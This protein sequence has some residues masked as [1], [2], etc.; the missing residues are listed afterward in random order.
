MVEFSLVVLHQMLM[1]LNKLS[2]PVV[3][4]EAEAVVI[5]AVEEE[6]AEAVV[7]KS[8]L[9]RNPILIALVTILYKIS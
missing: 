1:L 4:L 5:P 7:L 2:A 8:M 6:A 9:K 3:S